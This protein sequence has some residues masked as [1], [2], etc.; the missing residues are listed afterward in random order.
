METIQ[1]EFYKGYTIKT[2]YDYED[3]SMYWNDHINNM[4]YEN[5]VI[6]SKDR[7]S[8]TENT[9]NEDKLRSFLLEEINE[10]DI[11][12][13]I[14][15]L[16]YEELLNLYIYRNDTTL[17]D[18]IE[19]DHNLLQFTVEHIEESNYIKMDRVT[20]YCQGDLLHVI[21][22]G[23]SAKDHERI[24]ELTRMYCYDSPISVY[25]DEKHVLGG[26]YGEDEAMKEAKSMIDIELKYQR[27][28]A[29]KKRIPLHIRD[30]W[31][32]DNVCF[33]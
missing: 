20:G 33:S 15:D 12:V 21:T 10:R 26:V 3:A 29:I 30:S 2:C 23:E 9:D 19:E 28:D 27:K 6:F 16:D 4:N 22:F 17:I 31:I 32:R 13:N 11:V 5:V 7:Y 24:C 1:K 18:K 8:I 14:L 25:I